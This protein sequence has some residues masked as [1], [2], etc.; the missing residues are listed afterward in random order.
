MLM[1]KT[2]PSTRVLLCPVISYLSDPIPTIFRSREM[3]VSQ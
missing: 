3:S 2:H 1:P